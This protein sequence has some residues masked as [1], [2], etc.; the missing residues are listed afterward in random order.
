MYENIIELENNC[1]WSKA[2][3]EISAYFKQGVFDEKLAILYVRVCIEVGDLENAHSTIARG[4]KIDHRNPELWLML[5]NIYEQKNINQAYLCYENAFFFAEDEEDKKYIKAFMDEKKADSG[6]L[7]NKVSFVI[8]SYNT[9][10]YTKGCLESIRKTCLEGSYEIIVVDNASSDGSV[11]WLKQQKDIILQCNAENAGFPRGCNQGI[12]LADKNNDIFLLNNDTILVDNSLFW[13]RMGLYE[14][15][16]VG[17]TGSVSNYVPNLQSCGVM[18][19][20]VNQYLEYGNANNIPL[21]KAYDEKIYLVGFALLLKRSVLEEV[22]YLDERFSPGTY[23]DNDMG[24]ELRAAGYSVVLCRNSFIYHYGNG[25]GKNKDKWA[26]LCETNKK[27]LDEKWQFDTDRYEYPCLRHLK[28]IL[29]ESKNMPKILEINCGLGATLLSVLAE[30]PDATI[31]GTENR[32]NLYNIASRHFH[33]EKVQDLKN[34]LPFGDEK[35]DFIIISENE[36]GE[37]PDEEEIKNIEKY[38]APGGRLLSMNY[39]IYAYSC[40]DEIKPKF[41][42]EFYNGEDS[43]SDGNV[44]NEIINMIIDN[45]PEDYDNAIAKRFSWP[46]Y[47]HLIDIRKNILNWYPFEKD[48]DALEIGC[49][50]GAITSVLCE[51]CHSVTAVELSKRRATAALLRNRERENLEII[52]GNLNDIKFEKKFD[53]ITLIGVLEYQGKYTDGE[54]PYMDF[55]KKIKGLL[56]PDG[57]LLIAIENQY[58]LKY[59]CGARED[60]TEIPFNGMNQY[61]FS[62]KGINTF[63]RKGLEKLVKDSGFKNTFFY[64]PLPDYKLPEKIF[65]DR[66]LPEASDVQ[67]VHYYYLNPSSLVANERIIYKDVIENDVFPFFANSFLVECSDSEEIGEVEYVSVPIFRKKEYALETI[68]SKKQGKRCVE[69]REMHPEARDFAEKVLLNEKKMLSKGIEVAV[70]KKTERGIEQEFIEGEPFDKLLTEAYE[71]KNTE[72][73]YALWDRLFNNFCDEVIDTIPRNAIIRDGKIVWFDQE[74]GMENAEKEYSMFR[75][76]W[77]FYGSN[78]SC[79]AIIPFEQIMSH[80]GLWNR[81]NDFLARE[82]AFEQPLF[83]ERRSNLVGTF[84]GF[85]V[86]L[87]AKRHV[88]TIMTIK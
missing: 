76:I 20:T 29:Q 41:V 49:G 11:E 79:N 54:N 45:T 59:W 51:N 72:E 4:L 37:Y 2:L 24:I 69:K 60:H 78:N 13:L 5:G 80:Y 44:E 12:A 61:L 33:V 63:S 46:S 42:T 3:K 16:K 14:S 66:H 39:E 25:G 64:Y 28:R 50:L 71:K 10:E 87:L 53:Y 55:L 40:A 35:F 34:S 83:D 48:K 8:L 21:K 73:I 65:S 22:G 82:T 31:C 9:L 15:E 18:A 19:D 62:G 68:I 67:T 47:Y 36:K 58:G 27:K 81:Y 52:V 7:V 77:T 32:E 74:W 75:A 1:E 88:Q 84:G 56:K 38:L 17:A 6:F 85:D 30:Y 57:K 70:S 26:A 43:Y 23:E 86:S